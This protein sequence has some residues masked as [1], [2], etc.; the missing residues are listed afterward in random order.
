M[1]RQD[2][3]EVDNFPRL[4]RHDI[5]ELNPGASIELPPSRATGGITKVTV[6]LPDFDAVVGMRRHLGL[7]GQYTFDVQHYGASA[8]PE[9][10]VY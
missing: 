7:Y 2:P 3:Q 5:F 1:F 10:L 8:A 6:Q 4:L 9:A